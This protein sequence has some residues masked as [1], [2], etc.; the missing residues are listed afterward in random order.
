[1]QHAHIDNP[2]PPFHV[3]DRRAT[4]AHT[5]MLPADGGA[6]S[7]TPAVAAIGGVLLAPLVLTCA[8]WIYQKR[9]TEASVVV[10]YLVVNCGLSLLNRWGLGMRGFRFPLSMTALHMAFGS[11]AL[12]PLMALHSKYRAAHARA[13]RSRWRAIVTIGLLNCLQVDVFIQDVLKGSLS[14]NR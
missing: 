14:P 10:G 8:I 5:I 6:E 9:P 3:A 13:L 4:R 12:T 1:M 2:Q 11:V 7:P